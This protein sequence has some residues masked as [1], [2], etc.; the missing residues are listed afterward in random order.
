MIN[1]EKMKGWVA[2]GATQWFWIQN[3]WIGNPANLVIAPYAVSEA[4]WKNVLITQSILH[5]NNK[6]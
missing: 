4:P 6:L 5:I 2:L 3:T 1:L